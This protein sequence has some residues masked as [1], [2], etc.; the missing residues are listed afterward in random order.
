[1]KQCVST[2]CSAEFDCDLGSCQ[3]GGD[4][5]AAVGET[6]AIGGGGGSGAGVPCCD[7]SA[8]CV[9]QFPTGVCVLP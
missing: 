9:F 5:C 4:C 7:P 2:H 1:V 3:P 6:C 8:V